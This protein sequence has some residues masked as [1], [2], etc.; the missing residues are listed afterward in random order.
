MNLPHNVEF[1]SWLRFVDNLKTGNISSYIELDLR[2]GWRPFK[3][4]DI[5]LVGQ[6]L[7]DKH[8]PEFQPSFIVTQQTEIQRSVYG[9]ITWNF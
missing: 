3:R 6:N 9:K 1:D 7:L 2:L 5:S 4:W 8:H